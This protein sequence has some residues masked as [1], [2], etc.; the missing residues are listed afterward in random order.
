MSEP[1]EPETDIFEPPAIE[2]PEGC[3]GPSE[4]CLEP[5]GEIFAD[6]VEVF[7]DAYTEAVD[8]A[9]QVYQF[10]LTSCA[11]NTQ[12]IQDA[13]TAFLD[14]TASARRDYE[15]SRQQAVDAYTSQAIEQCCD[16]GD[17]GEED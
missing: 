1:I 2:C 7:A 15:E 10:A 13:A 14:A 9:D 8:A 3:T 6:A 11:G 4:E 16:C 17:D 12:C 5:L